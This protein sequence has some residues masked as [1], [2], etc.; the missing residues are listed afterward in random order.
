VWELFDG[1]TEYTTD[2][3]FWEKLKQL[4]GI[5]F[6]RLNPRTWTRDLLDSAN[7]KP[8]D[9]EIILCGMW[10]L[11]NS[12]NDCRHGKSPI[13]PGLAVEWAIEVCFHLSIGRDSDQGRRIQEIWT[14]PAEGTLKVNVDG[15][16]TQDTCMG[17]VGGWCGVALAHFV[18][19]LH[20]G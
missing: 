9:R 17:A 5:K 11:W 13:E 2:H 14:A 16:F 10:S 20:D 18:L 19:P 1:L 3:R 8:D 7:C 4:T 12:R 6:P 15:A